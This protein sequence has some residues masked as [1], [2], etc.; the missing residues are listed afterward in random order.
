M[1]KDKLKNFVITS[2]SSFFLLTS[3]AAFAV[4]FTPGDQPQLPAGQPT[5]QPA[6]QAQN[7]ELQQAQL[8]NPWKLPP[9]VL[10]VVRSKGQAALLRD[11]NNSYVLQEIGIFLLF[12][13]QNDA[14]LGEQLLQRAIQLNQ[15][16][17]QIVDKLTQ[18][19]QIAGPTGIQTADQMRRFFEVV[20]KYSP[21]DAN[22]YAQLAA[23]YQLGGEGLQRDFSKAKSLYEQ[24]LGLDP[25]NKIALLGLANILKQGGDGV[26]PDMGRANDLLT[27]YQQLQ[28]Q[29][30]QPQAQTSQAPTPTTQ[31]SLPQQGTPGQPQPETPPAPPTPPPAPTPTPPSTPMPTQLTPIPQ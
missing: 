7:A 25:N 4:T 2:A 27:R 26:N 15:N 10:E 1:K 12:G 6:S 9:D 24:A 16:N 14:A 19:I 22:S 17:P 31:G 13:D 23:V 5:A 21:N 8:A 11:P 20:I 29:K 3:Q 30:V 18:F 28:G